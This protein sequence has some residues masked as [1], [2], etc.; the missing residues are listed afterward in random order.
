[1][2][3]FKKVI[4]FGVLSAALAAAGVFVTS[5]GDNAKEISIT[6]NTTEIVNIL[7][8]EQKT[9]SFTVENFS[10][11]GEVFLS[12]TDSSG[13][14]E[15][16]SERAKINFTAEYKGGGL[17]EVTVVGAEG[18]TA[19]LV[20]KTK[21]GGNKTAQIQFNV[22]EFSSSLELKNEKVYVTPSK[23][24][25]PNDSIFTFSS[26]STE[27]N[28][29]FYFVDSPAGSLDESA[30]IAAGI[31]DNNGVTSFTLGEEETLS[32]RKFLKCEIKD[33]KLLFTQAESE[34]GAITFVKDYYDTQAFYFVAEYYNSANPSKSI[35]KLVKFNAFNGIDE[36]LFTVNDKTV[37]S[38]QKIGLVTFA[39]E[40]P[41][42]Q[43]T[44][45]V[46]NSEDAQL[47]FDYDINSEDSDKIQLTMESENLSD[48]RKLKIYNFEVKSKVAKRASA[49]INFNLYYRDFYG[50]EGVSITKTLDVEIYVKPNSMKVNDLDQSSTGNNYVLYNHN[51]GNY[52]WKELKISVYAE[53]STFTNCKLEFE[54]SKIDVK[55]GNAILTNGDS[56]S[57]ISEPILVRGKEGTSE[58]SGTI[59]LTLVTPFDTEDSSKITFTVNYSIKTGAT[60]LKFENEIYNYT[61][62]TPDNGIYLSNTAG[63]QIFKDIYANAAFERV[64]ITS[65][66]GSNVAKV[67]YTGTEHL[68]EKHKLKLKITPLK[69]GNETFTIRLDNGKSINA[70]I[71]VVE[72]FDSVNIE[73]YGSNTAVYSFDKIEKEEDEDINSKII[74]RNPSEEG[75]FGSKARIKISSNNGID[76]INSII[77]DGNYTN[78]STIAETEEKDVYEITTLTNGRA[79]VT[80]TIY[81]QGVENFQLKDDERK[82]IK[83]NI[84]AY[85]LTSSFSMLSGDEQAN[86]ITLFAGVEQSELNSVR[87]TPSVAAS[88]AYE[89]YQYGSNNADTGDFIQGLFESEYIFWTTSSGLKDK[90][91]TSFSRILSTDTNTYNLDGIV[92]FNP[93]TF[94]LTAIKDGSITLFA[95]IRQYGLVRT[96]AVNITVK[97]FASV[98]SINVSATG[99]K[100]TF[101]A[102]DRKK[103]FVVTATPD[104]ATILDIEFVIENGESDKKSIIKT[105][106][107]ELI[108]KGT[109]LV[110]VELDDEILNK[111]SEFAPSVVLKIGASDWKMADSKPYKIFTVIYQDGTEKYPYLLQTP[112]DVLNIK[113]AMSAYYTISNTIDLSV[114]ADKLPL[115]GIFSGTIIGENANAKISGIN[116][117][118]GIN[119]EEGDAGYYYGLFAKLA[120]KAVISNVIFEGSLK[121][122]DTSK[123]TASNQYLGIL[124]GY[125]EATLT[126]VSVYINA[127]NVNIKT[128]ASGSVIYIGAIGYNKGSITKKYGGENNVNVMVPAI[129]NETLNV[130]VFGGA[131]ADIYAGGIA[132]YNEG[133]IKDESTQP[134]TTGYLANLA[135]TLISISYANEKIKAAVTAFTGSIYLG[136]VAGYSNGK[137]SG[138]QKIK[139]TGE[140]DPAVTTVVSGRVYSNINTTSYV[141]GI[142]GSLQGQ[143]T[144]KYLKTRTRARG[145]INV[146]AIAAEVGEKKASDVQNIDIEEID[147][148]ESVDFEA[149][150]VVAF[151]ENSRDFYN[152]NTTSTEAADILNERQSFIALGNKNTDMGGEKGNNIT[153]KT[154]VTRKYKDLNVEIKL[155]E[156]KKDPD[157][158]PYPVPANFDHRVEFHYGSYLELVPAN[159]NV[160]AQHK[161]GE[162]TDEAV[163]IEKGDY[164]EEL[165]QN[166]YI[167]T[168]NVAS[169]SKDDKVELIEIK[170]TVD[171]ETTYTAQKGTE[172]P[173]ELTAAEFSKLKYA[174][175]R[176]FT[177]YY[178][179]AEKYLDSEGKYT[180]VDIQNAQAVLNERLNKLSVNSVLRPFKVSGGEIIIK[181]ESDLVTVDNQNNFI[182]NGTGL[183]KL[184]IYNSLNAREA[185]DVY[186]YIVN[187][188]NN[189]KMK[190]KT[191]YKLDER[192]DK[193]R[194]DVSLKGDQNLVFKVAPSYE[195]GKTDIGKFTEN[196]RITEDGEIY[197]DNW[198]IQLVASEVFKTEIESEVEFNDHASCDI[199]NN[200]I[201]ISKSSSP[202]KNDVKDSI[203]LKTSLVATVDGVKYEH[204]FTDSD[205][206]LSISY[207]EGASAIKSLYDTY[208]ISSSSTQTDTVTIESDDATEALNWEISNSDFIQSGTE[209]ATSGLFNV[210]IREDK[211]VKNISISI[212]KESQEYK[213]RYEK[214]IFGK[215]TVRYSATSNSSDVYKE[216]TLYVSD[217]NLDSVIFENYPNKD[218]MIASQKVVPSQY[219]IL[220]VT[221]A[222]AD[223]DFKTFI[224]ENSDSNYNYESTK[225]S[226]EVYYRTNVEWEAVDGVTYTSKGI[227]IDKEKLIAGISEYD[228]QF[229][230]RYLFGNTPSLKD[231]TPVSFNV[232]LLGNNNEAIYSDTISYTVDKQFILDFTIDNKEI[233]DEKYYLAKGLSYGVTIENSGFDEDTVELV[234]SDPSLVQVVMDNGKYYLNIVSRDISS[235]D[236]RSVKLSLKGSRVDVDGKTIPANDV[237][238]ECYVMEYVFN[239]NRTAD[240]KG[241]DI[242]KN[243]DDGLIKVAI[244]GVNT[245]ALD[246]S[247][248]LEYDA[249]NDAVVRSVRSFMDRAANNGQ[250][251]VYIKKDGRDVDWSKVEGENA[252]DEDFQILTLGTGSISNEYFDFNNLE[253]VIKIQHTPTGEDADKRYAFTFDVP[254]IQGNGGY[255]IPTTLV[256]GQ[257]EM[258]SY[259][260]IATYILGAEDTPNPIT[261]YAD[262]KT[263]GSGAHYILTSED[264]SYE[265]TP[266]TFSPIN[267][268]FASLD[269]NGK[270]ITFKKGVYAVSSAEVGLFSEISQDSVVKNLKIKFEDGVV[271]SASTTDS[272]VFGA[273]ASKNSGAITNANVTG[274]LTIT[275]ANANTSSFIAGIVG[276]NSG[277]ITN[278][279]AEDLFISAKGASLAGV[280]G[281]N[282]KTIA[283]SYFKGGRLL[284]LTEQNINFNTAGLVSNNTESGVVMTSFSSGIIDSSKIYSDGRVSCLNSSVQVTGGV[285]S[286]KGQ[287]RDCYSN[288][289]IYTRSNSSGFVYENSGSIKNCF[290][291]SKLESNKNTNYYFVAVTSIEGSGKGSLAN[292][293]YLK[294]SGVNESLNTLVVSGVSAL[295][296]MGFN[297]MSNFSTYAYGGSYNNVWMNVVAAG[298]MVY[299]FQGKIFAQ[300]RLEL[301]S[302]NIIASSIRESAGQ[303]TKDGVTTYTYKYKAGTP[304]P[305]TMLNPYIISS[306]E[307]FESNMNLDREGYFRIVNNLDY[308]DVDFTTFKTE[309]YGI[310]EGNG[311]IVTNINI[312][313]G[314]SLTS[315]G[316]IGSIKQALNNGVNKPDYAAI[317]NLT[318]IPKLTNFP[319]ASIVGGLVGTVENANVQNVSVRSNLSN[320]VGQ[321]TNTVI[322]SGKNIV[323]GVVGLVKTSANIKNIVSKVGA[324]ATFIPSEASRAI[325]TTG[326]YSGSNTA[327]IS[328]AGSVIGYAYASGLI[329]VKDV[330]VESSSAYAIADRAGFVFGGI[331]KN[332]SVETVTLSINDS[333]IIKSYSFGGLIAGECGGNI[334]DVMIT[335][336]SSK[337]APSEKVFSVDA[338]IP[339]A[340][341]GVVGYMTKGSLS[342]VYMGHSFKIKNVSLSNTIAHVG[343]IVG[344]VDNNGDSSIVSLSKIV[345][346]GSISAR[347]TLGGI[348]G[349]VYSTVKMDNIAIREVNLSVEGLLKNISVGGFIGEL[350]QNKNIELRNAYSWAKIKLNAFTYSEN[351]DAGVGAVIGSQ[352]TNSRTTFENVYTTTTYEVAL[353]NKSSISGK[354]QVQFV[355]KNYPNLSFDGA[356]KEPGL[357]FTL[358]NGVIKD[359]S[360]LNNL[361]TADNN[362]VYNYLGTT[363]TSILGDNGTTKFEARIDSKSENPKLT[364]K[365][366][367]TGVSICQWYSTINST[368]PKT[369]PDNEAFYGLIEH[370][371]KNGVLMTDVTLEQKTETTGADGSVTTTSMGSIKI[372][373]GAVLEELGLVSTG[374]FKGKTTCKVNN[375]D[376]EIY[377][378][379]TKA[380]SNSSIKITTDPISVSNVD[381]G[382]ITPTDKSSKPIGLSYLSFE[383]TLRM[384]K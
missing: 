217:Q 80:F 6:P 86:N 308:T 162:A 310:L 52:G 129:Y 102:S 37:F 39:S 36:S 248:Y 346:D 25:V 246:L 326:I 76:V 210:D 353:E 236:N 71:R 335:S 59:K 101:S 70:T 47:V 251:K 263:M 192:L 267:G 134:Q 186:L 161:F 343:G 362:V 253:Y 199:A 295:N 360:A 45:K 299:P 354:K 241:Y 67:E 158:S 100:L 344:Y 104:T 337:T 183:A 197:I 89:F 275:N 262:L 356:N 1:M 127:S 247:N 88:D 254:F 106:T 21:E 375:I 193:A 373:A 15:G 250:W 94:T 40:E 317:L 175:P 240:N 276:Y 311:M 332:V 164:S 293:Y 93:N 336:D 225:A 196:F 27:R 198:T 113:N 131:V 257:K 264:S 231:G 286:N 366:N 305:G 123:T 126:N 150:M 214:S 10:S 244:N 121:D 30:T 206:T 333:M 201:T 213:N 171:G 228:G 278:S 195:T 274:T 99:T 166:I 279:Q 17:T 347:N 97:A 378:G 230:I 170:T 358:T 165:L 69:V 239:Y 90:E 232:K 110:T 13:Y 312:T 238:R 207:Y 53:D 51:V 103:S 176:M 19:V 369:T 34:E 130:K 357:G 340:V 84:V 233:V 327:T 298:S 324:K 292:C 368:A 194:N 273:V 190:G 63:E 352:I 38:E 185:Q 188:F 234:S 114:Y 61:T 285:F 379:Q 370:I 372:P 111:S 7:V 48:D 383:Q 144:I 167:V 290:S 50:V 135:H 184:K 107:K 152:I 266:E 252:T 325:I 77:L 297:N 125:S 349:G 309:F 179:K 96:F 54:N 306:A 64:L 174:N 8:D 277:T 83:M 143:G 224:I 82:T 75:K 72:T 108:K 202:I 182:I 12:S 91:G 138:T 281:T 226:F 363:A 294:D 220:S 120:S 323:G 24:L 321:D 300:K 31:T 156:S 142:V 122:I 168:E 16:T 79:N 203:K 55:Q 56:V 205:A 85:K 215:Y 303:E 302:A 261:N 154:Y 160:Y 117:T 22:R 328:Y 314:K 371:V 209:S 322:V 32:T 272:L 177:A 58:D 155:A 181:S 141:G 255:S 3:N 140:T 208:S 235:S 304:Q 269:G 330:D 288:I 23:A 289:P 65:T 270:T 169:L 49:K 329:S 42:E 68:G 350:A 149:S 223:V 62:S 173:V 258:K 249:T 60:D 381:Y 382:W 384:P 133:N 128:T 78:I 139:V 5:C 172:T 359:S 243:Y 109:W 245:L 376:T 219:G 132:G 73:K 237:I 98:E 14:S 259:F 2:K 307:S 46:P 191:F 146:G 287:I 367:E 115:S 377:F 331:S 178:F 218:E 348:I 187:Y 216:I 118:R 341:G 41:A 20:A 291:T 163:T 148:G 339:R 355:Q 18:G 260:T 119:G 283:S 137:I 95:S 211:L 284:N 124:A 151:V 66:Q 57:D 374:K 345:M 380:G 256:E 112:E 296:K 342:S 136:G 9:V 157:S 265:I 11:N 153:F 361:N 301:V 43:F 105:P 189:Q 33:G 222:P 29:N 315:A 365:Q 116:I 200:L 35:Y 282:T 44:I 221:L 87:L 351:I 4:L 338:Y 268:I 92:E 319:N 74:I 204:K 145:Y 280:A 242:I 227:S 318:I 180:T 26:N 271:F 81:G 313:S 212:N 159:G 316:Y 364:L 320:E 147:D 229:Y 28:M 334:S